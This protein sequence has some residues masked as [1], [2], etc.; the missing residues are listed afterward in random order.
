[1]KIETN[2]VSNMEIMCAEADKGCNYIIDL[3]GMWDLRG[4]GEKG[5][6]LSLKGQVPG[7]VHM[8]LLREGLI[9]D[10]FYRKQADECQ[11]VEKW[12]W[13][14][15]REFEIPE[16]AELENAYLY[17]EGLDTYAEI[18]INGVRAGSTDNMYMPWYF[19]VREEIDTDSR[20]H[21]TDTNDRR[22]DGLSDEE[23]TQ[24][25]S[26]VFMK[27]GKNKISVKFL[28]CVKMVEDMPY[29][30][31][32]TA[33]DQPER[34][35]IRRISC[36]FYWDWV[37]RFVTAGIW[38]PVSIVCCNRVRLEDLYVYTADL[39]RTSASLKLSFDVRGSISSGDRI[40]TEIFDPE[41]NCVWYE[42]SL[43]WD[44][45]I[46]L[47]ADLANPR[48]WWPCGYGEQPLYT[49]RI[50]CMD[51]RG[52][53][54]DERESVFGIR[55]VRI[56]QLQDQP[57]SRE[58]ERTDLVRSYNPDDN[59]AP[60]PGKSFTLLI[61]G[62]R[63]FCKGGN[64]VPADP[65]PA[66][67][68]EEKYDR[69]IRLARDGNINLLR[70]W[71]GGIYEPEEFFRACDRY[72]V[73]VSQDFNMACGQYPEDRQDFVEM[74][75]R[76]VP[77]VVKAL[78]NHPS[79]VWWCGDNE[80]SMGSDF[81]DPGSSGRIIYRE[82]F[83]DLM[84][85][86][87]P[88]RPFRMTSPYGGR[89]N[90]CPTIGDCHRSWWMDYGS[91]CDKVD[92]Y[93]KYIKITG[94]FASEATLSGMPSVYSLRKF[95]SE[96]DIRSADRDIMEYHTKNN[97]HVPEGY[98]TLY[99]ML[100]NGTRRC[101]GESLDGIE[102]AR[103]EGYVQYEWTRLTMEAARRN[104]FYTSGF[105]Y[106]MYNDCWPAIGWSMVD[107]YG[108]PKAAYY[109]MRKAAEPVAVSL[110]DKETEEGT[111]LECFVLN[112]TLVARQGT[113]A[114]YRVHTK[115]RK[116]LILQKEFCCGANDNMMAAQIAPGVWERYPQQ[117]TV[118]VCE[119]EGEFGCRRAFFHKGEPA[120]MDFGTARVTIA[121]CEEDKARGTILFSS[122]GYARVVTVE[123]DVDLEDNYFDL[124]PGETR[125]IP[126]RCRNGFDVTEADIYWWNQE[127]DQD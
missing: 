76:E 39:A 104:R 34:L 47:Q 55:T 50:R 59:S 97:P 65:F 1:M 57:G 75:R 24:H 17:F 112:D 63:I 103:K 82:V 123:G 8:D 43:V 54:L 100:E 52:R 49:C 77:S 16:D 29:K 66:S 87:D 35:F 6:T 111:T 10:M 118:V 127:K 4:Y 116:E 72:G 45:C 121:V 36:T 23:T 2:S 70:S 98:P 86:L 113:L 21:V 96:E 60:M 69:L 27:K 101:L 71:G 84:P 80:N 33:F 120:A 125:C 51:D 67:V 42:E 90:N 78:R 88:S 25:Y 40:L 18:T 95:M 5:E 107:Y 122:E 9:P 15:E 74:I 124:L 94:R 62:E 114:V 22:G 44:N 37:N 105:Q 11:W 117:E 91:G 32:T 58:A 14:Y 106:W 53:L 38:R 109:A 3:N 83:R 126:Y 119:I 108:T 68:T 85:V 102:K 19:A 13:E 41:G 64:W 61:N 73:M 28:P 115:G 20:S 26:P 56:E 89:I 31:Y 79:L 92:D 99:G 48:L 12:I 7:Q 110:N 30:N 93:K 81:D 46:S